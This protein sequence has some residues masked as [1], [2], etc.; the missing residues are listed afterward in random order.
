MIDQWAIG[1]RGLSPRPEK[2]SNVMRVNIPQGIRASD[3][4]PGICWPGQ[5]PPAH[6]YLVG[7]HD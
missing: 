5:T 1:P 3:L 4:T 2:F 7:A 6:P